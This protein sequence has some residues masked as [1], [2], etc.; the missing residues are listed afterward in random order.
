MLISPLEM[1]LL[2]EYLPD[3]LKCHLLCEAFLPWTS[4]LNLHPAMMSV[5]F[6]CVI[7][8]WSTYHHLT[9]CTSHGSFLSTFCLFGSSMSA[10]V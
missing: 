6:L 2:P 5:A 9:Y 4:D 1:F 7:F 3:S 8:L 10:G